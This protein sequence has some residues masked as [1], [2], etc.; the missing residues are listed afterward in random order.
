MTDIPTVVSTATVRIGS[1]DMVVHQLSDGQ[2]IIE[3]ESM[4]AFMEALENGT[5]IVSPDESMKLAKAIRP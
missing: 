3:A 4:H 5:L 1:L 2:R